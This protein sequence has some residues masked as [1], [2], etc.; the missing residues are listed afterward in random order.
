MK[1]KLLSLFAACAL[2]S[3]LA[4]DD[5]L[6][7]DPRL[8]PSYAAG[9]NAHRLRDTDTNTNMPADTSVSIADAI[10]MALYAGNG[11][12]Q[13]NKNV[14]WTNS[15]PA[16]VTLTANKGSA[17]AVAQAAGTSTVCAALGSSSSCVVIHVMGAANTAPNA[18]DDTFEAIGNAT[19][20]VPAPGVLGND[21][22][23]EQPVSA[24]P[25]TIT[26]TNGG[27]VQMS[28]DGSFTYLSAA[29]FSGADSFAYQASDGTATDNATVTMN[30]NGRVWY[31]K[32]DATAPGDGR[33]VSPFVLLKDA[34]SASAANEMVF[35]FEGNGTSAGYSDGF[36]FKAGQSLVGQGI[37]SDFTVI[38][39]GG[40]VTL[41][42]AGDY[43]NISRTGDVAIALAT[44]NRLL[45]VAVTSTGGAGVQGTLFGTFTASDIE[46]VTTGAT[47]VSLGGGGTVTVT[48]AKNTIVNTGGVALDV[49]NA[50]IGAAGI[51]FR[52]ISADG[53][54][55]GIV[56]SNTGTQGGLTVTGSGA[57]GSGGTIQNM[58]GGD[59]LQAG[60]GVWLASTTGASLSQM[61]MNGFTNHA[62]RGTDVNGFALLASTINGTSGD[63]AALLEGAVVIDQ[64]TGSSQVQSSTI[65][66]GVSDNMRVSNTSGAYTLSL[67]GSTIQNNH[68]ATGRHGL[69]VAARGTSSATVSIDN[70]NFLFNRSFGIEALT[71][72]AGAMNIDVTG[73]SLRNNFVGINLVHGSSG[74]F[75]FDVVN[76]PVILAHGASPIN[77]NRITAPTATGLFSGTV[78]GNVIGVAGVGGSG[79]A[80]G[81][82]IRASTSGATGTLTIAITGNTIREIATSRGIDIIARDGGTTL[83][84]TVTGNDILLTAP[85]ALEGIRIDAGALSTDTVKL[86]AAISGNTSIANAASRGIR[87]RQ[88]FASTTFALAGYAGAPTDNAAVIAFLAA[89][90]TSVPAPL[91]DNGGPGFTG[92]AS[93]PA[94]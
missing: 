7:S 30:V 69:Q 3:P 43:S 72:N 85:S 63:N 74:A 12:L 94:P 35:V 89:T 42:E 44:N 22:D 5:A 92:V 18:N 25:G 57:P 55:N 10:S 67:D 2:L 90:N 17:T 9:G 61:Q 29:G 66:G 62:I 76:I 33:D 83:N 28:A 34:E 26:T 91:A 54:P 4:C 51:N 16:A 24:V 1:R 93:C 39:N 8:D 32:N 27:T 31:A 79:S 36:I 13:N 68:A 21:T 88:R 48:G 49:A 78:S 50:T 77:V 58:A 75:T 64:L 47:A 71:E 20:P 19:I 56:L 14:V 37:A 15:N 86:C 59:G 52:S 82:A 38:L 60:N 45:G 46:V 41:L 40:S 87:I 65:S 23:A 6:V 70:S 73:G 80:T 81:P 11:S 84:A 53:G